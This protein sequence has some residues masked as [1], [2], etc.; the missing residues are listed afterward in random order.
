[1]DTGQGSLR[2]LPS[3]WQSRAELSTTQSHTPPAATAQSLIEAAMRDST[4]RLEE[5]TF[6]YR[7]AA[8]GSGNT[9]LTAG[10]AGNAEEPMTRAD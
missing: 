1:M 9:L 7:R 8:A 5:R 3:L 2:T 10:V 6:R 4:R